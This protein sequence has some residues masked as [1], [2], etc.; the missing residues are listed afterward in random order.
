MNWI[1]WVIV[2]AL[3]AEAG[4][5]MAADVANLRCMDGRIPDE[6]IGVY[7]SERYAKAQAYLKTRTRFA[8]VET[9]FDLALVMGF[10]FL[11]G[12]AWLDHWSRG[13][14]LAPVLT[15]LVYVG[16]LIL[17]KWVAGLPL[18]LYAT[19]VIEARFGFNRT[20]AK[21]FASDLGKKIIL[22]AVLGTP[23][24]AGVL[25][26]FHY[27]GPA[28]WWI[29]WLL[30]SGFI[31][32]IQYVAPT[33]IMPLFNRFSPLEDGDLRQ[34]LFAYAARI[35]FP[36]ENVMIMDG[37]RRSSRANAFFTGFGRHRRIVLFDTLVKNHDV[38]E[39]L[40]VLAHEMGH[41]KLR[42]VAVMTGVALLQAGLLFFILSF[43]LSWPP[44]FHAFFVATPSV[45]A[46]LVFF[47]L[48]Y[49]P[50]DFFLG[51][52]TQWLS[53][54]NELAAD[55]FAAETTRSPQHLGRALKKLSVDNLTPIDPHPFYVWLNHSH[56]PALRRI[57]M[58][59]A[60]F[61]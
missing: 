47:A 35:D 55:R 59:E 60:G 2:T 5:R 19:F 31:L 29:C 56:P 20:T 42:H 41:Y 44:L 9:V 12:F 26:F 10:W 28:G 16:G 8:W 24:A 18:D 3:V 58:L 22:A 23:V 52:C 43:F 30:V 25:S 6:F 46:G 21:V 14:D 7:D 15:G 54:K 51:I 33:W 17:A 38:D 45:H 37:S 27:A 36:L 4:L 49:T 50:V 1:G 11:H 34:A 32:A 13:L 40:G 53:R 57:R 48:L 61:R 39:L